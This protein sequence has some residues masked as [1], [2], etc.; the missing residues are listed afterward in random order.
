MSEQYNGLDLLGVIGGIVTGFVGSLIAFKNSKVTAEKEF[1]DD[2]LALVKQHSERITALED[3]NR[4][5]LRKNQELAT[6]NLQEQRK[7]QEMSVKISELESEK[8][9]MVSQINYLENR[10]REV[11]ET[12]ERIIHERRN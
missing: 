7:Q 5:L 10:L 11:S 2:L 8:T 12:L 1:R 3:E 6:L 9:K 4:E